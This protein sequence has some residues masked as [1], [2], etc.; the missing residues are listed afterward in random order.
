MGREDDL[1]RLHAALQEE[2]PVGI[3]GQGGVGKTQLAVVYAYKYRDDYPDGIYWL[4][5]AT[6]WRVAFAKLADG[7]NLPAAG[8]ATS[9][10]IDDRQSIVK[11]LATKSG[12]Q[13]GPSARAAFLT[14][15]GLSRF[16]A[17]LDL[18]G[19][20]G[21]MSKALV[22][23]LEPF[24][25]L[26]EQPTHHALGALLEYV[27]GLDDTP[28]DD[29]RWL[30]EGIDR[31]Q[32]VVSAA[33]PH[34]QDERIIATFAWLREHPQS[35][36]ILD[37]V[38]DPLALD[39]PLTRDCVPARLPGRVLFTTRQ[40]EQ[41]LR[42]QSVELNTLER[43]AS[44]ELLLRSRGGIARLRQS[45]SDYAAANAICSMLGDLPLALEIAAAQ[46]Q[47]LFDVSLDEYHTELRERNALEVLADPRSPVHVRHEAG[48]AALLNSQ[49]DRLSPEAQMLMRVAGQLVEA[50]NVPAARLGLFAGIPDKGKSVFDLTYRRVIGRLADLR[51]LE[52][53][54]G[55]RIRL[56]PLV[57][58]FAHQQTPRDHVAE[59]R[60]E[61]VQRLLIALNDIETLERQ[62]DVRGIDALIYDLISAQSLL[63]GVVDVG[64]GP[65]LR[66][67]LRILRREAHNLRGWKQANAPNFLTQQLHLRTFDSK[68]PGLWEDIAAGPRS[69]G[70]SWS[71]RW[72]GRSASPELEMTLTGHE[73]WVWAVGVTP[74]GQ[75]AISG[76]ADG[77]L[78]VWDMT[79]GAA[80]QTLIGHAGGVT[81][82]AV[83]PDG[84]RAVSGGDDGM[85]RVWNLDTSEAERTLDGSIGRVRAVTVMPDGRRLVS[86]S[87]DGI[88]R[89]WDI[90][91]GTLERT[92]TGHER[93]GA[94]RA[95]DAGWATSYLRRGRRYA[96]G[97]EFNNRGIKEDAG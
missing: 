20:A 46:L 28:I 80:A 64:V 88:L 45:N 62:C 68:T 17:S 42:F 14:D 53:L 65:S 81:A 93:M 60:T 8:S 43:D 82:L 85:L 41:G 23:R 74:D 44:L 94:G 56:H 55:D 11:I 63:E 69:S 49:W 21:D 59:F 92:L 70:Q 38:T 27:A 79:T 1:A 34:S 36:I 13:A 71:A 77:T 48:L 67:C 15:A 87:E 37:N 3:T 31:Y 40:G 7:L 9:L 25:I 83:T 89:I 58:S 6:E 5:A 19:A 2:G 61:C 47:D 39:E 29:G 10:G 4:N 95:G 16:V 73:G 76:G 66:T 72:A 90:D 75:R 51:L 91:T 96:T 57:Y 33:P 26:P 97:V 52:R 12:L 35:L 86:G 22:T 30:R 78:R 32:L 24:G 50:T 18:S 84:R 54:E